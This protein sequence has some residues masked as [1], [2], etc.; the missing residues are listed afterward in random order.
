M[1]LTPHELHLLHRGTVRHPAV[2][3][4]RG[5][6]TEF[7]FGWLSRPVTT[8]PAWP[9]AP[10]D[11]LTDEDA[12]LALYVCYE[13]HYRGFDGVDENWEWEPSLLGLR[14]ELEAVFLADVRDVAGPTLRTG[15]V[16]AALR[17]L[18][19]AGDGPSLSEYVATDSTIEQLMEFHVHRS[20][21]QL[22]EADAHSWALPRLSG[23]A[24]AALV[25]IQADEYGQ[26]VEKDMHSELFALC[27]R[28]LGLDDTYGAYLDVIPAA[29]LATV[30]LGSFFG[31]HRRWR[32]A[33]VGHLAVFEMTS[34]EP[35]G[36]YSMALRRHGYGSW[37]RLFYDTHVVADAHHQTL[38]ARDLAGG[39]L[40]AEPELCDDVMFGAQALSALE[41]RLTRHLLDRWAAGRSSLLAPVAVA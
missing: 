19:A 17:N 6:L 30:N 24:K 8:L 2:P 28:E 29:T 7:L 13:L 36:R 11:L 32:G 1:S 14:R 18:L 9:A 10:V 39:L 34:V 27:M 31:L 4:P 38:A 16:E 37:A 26:G 33:L 35:M 3:P 15:D 5:P 23:T 25:E 20:A 12:V 40:R 21:Y 22:K 41:G